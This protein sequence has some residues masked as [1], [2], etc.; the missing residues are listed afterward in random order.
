MFHSWYSDRPWL[1]HSLLLTLNWRHLL[2][3]FHWLKTL[4]GARK[5]R[6]RMLLGRFVC[7]FNALISSHTLFAFSRAHL[8][9][10]TRFVDSMPSQGW[11]ANTVWFVVYPWMDVVD[12]LAYRAR[13][14][15]VTWR[16][17]GV[18]RALLAAV[19]SMR[20]KRWPLRNA[21]C[22]ALARK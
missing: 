15:R 5:E 11:F 12:S 7:S 1:V 3:E 18:T 2:P 10:R 19:D 9:L 14:P 8:D 13:R 21:C 22:M 16:G 4:R 17:A 6:T 20:C